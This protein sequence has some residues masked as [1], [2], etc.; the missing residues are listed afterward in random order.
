MVT[1]TLYNRHEKAGGRPTLRVDYVSGL[2]VVAREWIC[3]EHDGWPKQK[4]EGWWSYRAPKDSRMPSSV[5]EAIGWIGM[6][7]DLR[8]PASITVNETGKY[9][10]VVGYDFAAEPATA[11]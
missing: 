2:R 9:P 8:Q 3:L 6:G 7:L 4:A 1:E 5:D 11:S 10:E